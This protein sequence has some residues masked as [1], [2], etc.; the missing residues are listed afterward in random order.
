MSGS[1]GNLIRFVDDF[2]PEPDLMREIALRSEYYVPEHFYG[3]RSARGFLPKGTIEKIQTAFGF[4]RIKLINLKHRSGHF[5]PSLGRGKNRTQFFA[6]IDGARS[7][8]HPLFSMVVYLS[9]RP[10]RDSGTGVFRHRKTGLWQEPTAEDAERLGQTQEELETQLEK[11][12]NRRSSWEMLD[13]SENVYN[14]AVLFPAHWYHSSRR[15]FGSR[16]EMG[17]LYQ[18]FFFYGYPNVFD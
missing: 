15:D 5:Y 14:R 16:L 7:A 12:A 3:Q 2:Y 11:D 10:P 13:C 18:A 17:R 4:E 9:P 8:Q 1:M 6:H